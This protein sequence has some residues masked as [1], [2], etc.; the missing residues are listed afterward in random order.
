MLQIETESSKALKL[1]QAGAVQKSRNLQVVK[2][3]LLKR[4]MQDFIQ[5]KAKNPI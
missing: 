2:A 3:I 1:A 4:R 5:A